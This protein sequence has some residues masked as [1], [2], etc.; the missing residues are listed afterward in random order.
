M[1]QLFSPRYKFSLWRKL[2]LELARC[3]KAIS[4]AKLR[5]NVLGHE[6]GCPYVLEQSMV[7]IASLG[8]CGREL[9]AR[10]AEARVYRDRVS[11]LDDRFG[12]IF[13]RDELVA[14]R[15][16]ISLQLLRI[17]RT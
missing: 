15:H 14:A 2:W 11:I 4:R 10:L 8:V 17:A 7:H 13:L 9:E 5:L 3:Q 1:L 6:V 16:V 12:I